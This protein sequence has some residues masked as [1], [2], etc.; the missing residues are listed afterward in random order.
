MQCPNDRK[1]DAL[2]HGL[3]LTITFPAVSGKIWQLPSSIENV[4]F[5]IPQWITDEK[6]CLDADEGNEKG[7]WLHAISVIF[8][9]PGEIPVLQGPPLE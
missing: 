9:L 5:S 2:D 1:P 4:N 8:S 3:H 7:D 6:P